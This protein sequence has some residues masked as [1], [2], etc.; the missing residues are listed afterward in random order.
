MSIFLFLLTLLPAS[1]TGTWAL[2]RAQS[3]FGTADVPRQFV[4]QIEQTGIH[5]AATVFNADSTG[6]RVI[7]RQCRIEPSGALTCLDDVDETWQVIGAN[8]L[9][10][11]RVITAK[12]QAVRQRL[13]LERSTLLEY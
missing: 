5:L 1:L 13:V 2:D 8:E 4:L 10:I 3:D 7:Y 6:Q 12:S 9:T 11:R